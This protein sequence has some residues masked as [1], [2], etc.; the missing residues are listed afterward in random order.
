MENYIKHLL[1]DIKDAQRK[2][3]SGFQSGNDF[4]SMIEDVERFTK[5]SLNQDE[6]GK[7]CGLDKESFP[8]SD[9]LVEKELKDL[10]SAMVKMYE[11]W[12]ILVHLPDDLPSK[13]AYE[14]SIGLL[15]RNMPVM[16]HGF[17][18]M[19]FCTGNPEGCEFKE[20]CP[21]LKY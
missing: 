9:Q 3:I 13:M 7:V 2:Q 8:P 5:K 20:Y 17:F 6:F 21:C 19:D 14:L 12:N 11:S 18:G 16:S 1:E 10:A 15:S 4:E